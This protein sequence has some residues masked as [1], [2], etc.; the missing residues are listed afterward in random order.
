MN[1]II[2]GDKYTKGMKSKGCPALIKNKNK[3]IIETQY[4]ILKKQ[5]DHINI[6]YVYGFDS[7]RFLSYIS[8]NDKF[9]IITIFNES[10]EN[11]NTGYALSL[12]KQ[13]LNDNTIILNGYSKLTKTMLKI[14][15]KN[16]DSK[17]FISDNST[18]GIG[19][20]INNDTIE[21]ISYDLENQIADIFYLNKSLASKLSNL[22]VSNQ[23]HNAFL[24]ELLNKLIDNGH[25]IKSHRI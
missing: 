12:A 8:K 17:I 4:D 2:L 21:N 1:C 13:F 5:F 18:S 15:S 6:I 23:H 10:Y 16:L 24:F 11:K 3:T 19:C 7:K 9:N 14:I 20:I 25:I 22:L